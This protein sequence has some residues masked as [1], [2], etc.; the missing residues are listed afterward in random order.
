MCLDILAIA[1]KFLTWHKKI[2]FST[3]L[4]LFGNPTYM[5]TYGQYTHPYQR[6]D[7]FRYICEEK[8]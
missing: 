1:L 4:D 8:M 3:N 2:Y 6:Y 5:Y 7:I